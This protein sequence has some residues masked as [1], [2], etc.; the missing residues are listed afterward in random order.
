MAT[1]AGGLMCMA[2]MLSATPAAASEP[3]SIPFAPFTV[4][5]PVEDR[6]ITI[7][8]S[9]TATAVDL[10]DALDVRADITVS[11]ADLQ[12]QI[13]AIV[14]KKMNRDDD[15]N[16]KLRVN[17][18]DLRATPPI[19][20]LAAAAHY[21]KWACAM[22]I[23][24]R[25][26]EQN[27]DVRLAVVPVV[28]PDTIRVTFTLLSVDAD[29]ALGGLLRDEIF[30]AWLLDQLRGLIP[31][32]VTVARLRDA[33]PAVLHEIPAALTDVAI[34]D[35]GGG[36]PAIRGTLKMKIGADKMLAILSALQEKGKS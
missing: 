5:V 30:G 22:G 10:G 24:T 14:Q 12:S 34:V 23:K 25:L 17:T 2:W 29:G 8:I 4:S 27:G 32:N 7:A 9:G 35:S 21:E 3:F 33:L 28:E 15:C 20:T 18:V 1:F 31:K 19:A 16:E 6:L 13:A 11:L 26:F 36:V